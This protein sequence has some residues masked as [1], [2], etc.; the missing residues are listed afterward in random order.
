MD[1]QFRGSRFIDRHIHLKK[2]QTMKSPEES[3]VFSH[4]L[5]GDIGLKNRLV[6][7]A[8]YENAATNDGRVTEKLISIYREL[9][10]GG[11]GLIITGTMGV[12]ENAMSYR[13]GLGIYDD[14]FI[15]D[16]KKI[17]KTVRDADRTC[18]IMAQVFRF[19][20]RWYG[21]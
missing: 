11:V 8:T 3:V 13:F 20:S 17:P 18:K 21:Y 1:F 12:S 14:A 10:E 7:S 2:E 15:T 16:L 6:R 9:A 4:C 19:S 5:I